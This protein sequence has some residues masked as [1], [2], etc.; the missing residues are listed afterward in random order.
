MRSHTHTVLRFFIIIITTIIII[1]M[2]IIIRAFIP[3]A[4]VWAILLGW[5]SILRVWRCVL[6]LKLLLLALSNA[7]FL[8]SHTRVKLFS[9]QLAV[10]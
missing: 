10:V 5:S 4:G 9:S 3:R 8:F 1:T 2:I 6:L 7:L